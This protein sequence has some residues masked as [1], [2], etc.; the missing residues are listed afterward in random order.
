MILF[1]RY[2][3]NF[4]FFDFLFLKFRNKN[5]VIIECI[6]IKSKN[7]PISTAHLSK[8]C[9]SL[10]VVN[11]K[12][13]FKQ[14]LDINEPPP[15]KIKFCGGNICIIEFNKYNY[16]TDE[17][18]EILLSQLTPGELVKK[19]VK[20]E[21]L[22]KLKDNEILQYKEQIK[23]CRCDFNTNMLATQIAMKALSNE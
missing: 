4:S 9:P 17:K 6:I 1:Q 16:T 13:I 21:N 7:R 11:Y 12:N 14:N 23:F 5:M 20:L 18:K 3:R 15:P 19:I 8:E 2:L 10:K 22:I